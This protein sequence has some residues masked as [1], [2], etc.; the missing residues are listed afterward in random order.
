LVEKRKTLVEIRFIGKVQVERHWTL[1]ARPWITKSKISIRHSF[2]VVVLRVSDK[3]AFSRRVHGNGASCA[4]RPRS[5][6]PIK[7][8]SE[9]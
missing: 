2:I 4:I 1:V 6:Q 3:N 8:P 9:K 7:R 5:A